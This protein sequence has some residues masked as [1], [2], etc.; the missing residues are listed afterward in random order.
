MRLNRFSSEMTL[1]IIIKFTLFAL[2]W[3]LFF[4]GQK[5]N[6]DEEALTD[7]LFNSAP[8]HGEKLK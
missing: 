2:V 5:I 8:L 6:V 1:A 3:W 7:R 4:A